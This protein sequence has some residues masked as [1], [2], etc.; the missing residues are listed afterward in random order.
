MYR[1][2]LVALENTVADG[3]LL[4]HVGE[5]AGHF[6]SEL[7]L[8]HVAD[9]FGARNFKHLKLAESEE[10][11]ADRAYLEEVAARF[12]ERGLAV[13]THLAMGE[14]SKEIL[15]IAEGQRC[16]L[17]AMGSHGHRLLGDLFF[18]STVHEVRHGTSIPVLIIRAGQGK[19]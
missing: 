13:S 4:P 2:I 16:D 19:T 10:I 14:P 8:L 6:R 5:L 12:R 7:L 3:R 18:G 11:R 1:K 17:I 15:K 9:G